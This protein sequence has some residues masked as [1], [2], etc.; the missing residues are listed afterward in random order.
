[1]APQPP[2]SPDARR[3]AISLNRELFDSWS[4][5][6]R[7]IAFAFQGIRLGSQIPTQLYMVH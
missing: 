3:V 6:G 4:P 5:D 7:F 1:M 2:L